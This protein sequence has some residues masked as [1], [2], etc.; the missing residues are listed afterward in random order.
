[1]SEAPHRNAVHLVGR[2]QAA[3]TTTAGVVVVRI[4][5]PDPKADA[6]SDL[7]RVE[8]SGK[9]ASITRRL[10]PGDLV[11]VLGSIHYDDPAGCYATIRARAIERAPEAET[12]G[13][14]VLAARLAAHV[15]E[16]PHTDT[17]ET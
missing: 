10:S 3:P 12:K 1:M 5:T 9:L 17:E 11:G 6:V 13:R 15:E 16:D 7:H 14:D 2:V 8:C 4:A